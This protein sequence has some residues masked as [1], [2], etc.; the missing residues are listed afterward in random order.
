MN[1]GNLFEGFSP[2]ECPGKGFLGV[3]LQNA[4]NVVFT[5]EGGSILPPGSAEGWMQEMIAPGPGSFII[6]R[7]DKKPLL[8]EYYHT[9]FQYSHDVSVPRLQLLH[10]KRDPARDAEAVHVFYRATFEDC[11]SRYKSENEHDVPGPCDD[12][13]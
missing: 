10:P 2:R 13:L 5:V 8:Q 7:K 6:V 1:P 9:L 3:K 4:E 11:W 12:S